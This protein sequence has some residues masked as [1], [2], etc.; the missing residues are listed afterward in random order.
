MEALE[1]ILTRRSVPKMTDEMPPKDHLERLLEAGVR[2][3]THHLTEPW[4]FIVLAG[5]ERVRLGEA[6]AAGAAAEGQDPDK[7]KDK[8]LRAPV[9]ICVIGRPKHHLPKVIEVE[10]HHAVGA[11]MQ[12][13]LLAAHALGLGAMIRT[14][15]AGFY[16]EVRDYLGL[17]KDEHVAGFIYVGYPADGE[18]PMTRRTAWAERTEWRG[19]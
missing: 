14:G 17:E 1:A 7:F 13:I 3:P 15:A 4:R 10:E 9:I 18:R 12:N 8:G 5:D 2:A 6:W 11:A 19:M 16:D